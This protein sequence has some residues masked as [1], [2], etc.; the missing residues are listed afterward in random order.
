MGTLVFFHGLNTYGDDLLHLGPLTF[1]MMH[2]RLEKG[3]RRHKIDFL[4][5]TELGGSDSPELQAERAAQTFVERGL[6]KRD[7][8]FHFLGHSIGGLVARALAARPEFRGRVRNIMTMGTP[9]HGTE[10]A[11]FGLEFEQRF[12]R[13]GQFFRAIGYDTR[14][15]LEI[16]QQFTP[17]V[18]A[19]F[20][21]LYPSLTDVRELTLLCACPRTELSLPFQALYKYIHP[22]TA[23]GLGAS[24]GFIL[25]ESQRRGEVIDT[26]ALDHLGEL[27]F[28]FHLSPFARQRAEKEFSRL[29]QRVVEIVTEVPAS[30]A[31]AL[32]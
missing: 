14:K 24:D 25:C 31:G 26:F 27:G 11:F 2:S 4:P 9:H 6:L 12:P 17:E 1:G 23:E 32:R 15:K 5:M 16:Y 30:S 29:V 22:A 8:S 13:M 21:R 7:G 19:E 18:V 28:F 20:N 3:F 10:T